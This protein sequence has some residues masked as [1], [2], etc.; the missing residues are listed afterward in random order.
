VINYHL[1]SALAAQRRAELRA[2]MRAAR[3]PGPDRPWPGTTA[4]RRRVLRRAAGWLPGGNG[5]RSWPRERA[6]GR[7]TVLRDGSEVL[8]RPIRGTEATR[9]FQRSSG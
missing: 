6:H 2:D 4:A 3:W 7:Q 5:W 1:Q 9:V 8:I